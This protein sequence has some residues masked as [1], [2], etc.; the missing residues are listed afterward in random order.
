MPDPDLIRGLVGKHRALYETS[1][2]F[3]HQIHLLANLLPIWVDGL[4]AKAGEAEMEQEMALRLAEVPPVYELGGA[5]G[6]TASIACQQGAHDL[7]P[8]QEDS[9]GCYC[10]CHE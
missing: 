4:A 9:I 2:G 1:A 3:H 6:R 8:S 5:I 7:C 10:R